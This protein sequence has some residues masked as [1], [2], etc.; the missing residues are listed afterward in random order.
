[1]GRLL[2]VADVPKKYWPLLMLVS[3]I[4]AAIAMFVMRLFV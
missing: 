3:V 2:G 1:M 4:N